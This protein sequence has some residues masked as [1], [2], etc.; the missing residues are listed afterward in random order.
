MPGGDLLDNGA[1][2][3][4]MSAADAE[5]AASPS[6]G[7]RSLIVLTHGVKDPPKDPGEAMWLKDEKRVARLSSTSILASADLSGH[8]IATSQPAL[9]RHLP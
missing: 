5:I 7:A 6:L 4:Y 2:A 3:Y 8:G 1:E 9:S